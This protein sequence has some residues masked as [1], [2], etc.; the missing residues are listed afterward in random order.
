MERQPVQGETAD[1]GLESR[2]L[3]HNCLCPHPTRDE[4]EDLLLLGPTL[5]PGRFPSGFHES[6]SPGP[7]SPG[8]AGCKGW[9]FSRLKQ[10]KACYF[11]FNS[12]GALN[13]YEDTYNLSSNCFHPFE[14]QGLPPKFRHPASRGPGYRET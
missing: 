11:N 2:H 9:N 4:E 3:A 8:H 12:S 10:N 6:G 1:L 13:G 7:T 14:A 5:S